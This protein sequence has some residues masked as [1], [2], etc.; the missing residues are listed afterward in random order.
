MS[1]QTKNQLTVLLNTNITD[2]LNKQNTA[3]KVREV[4]QS[5]IDS[6][7]ILSGSNSFVGDQTITGSLIV[8]G[9][10]I[11]TP[12]L[13]NQTDNISTIKSYENIINHGDLLIPLNC[14]FIVEEDAQYLI[15]GELINN[16]T[17]IVSGSLIANQGITGPGSVVGSGTVLNN[18]T[19]VTFDKANQA[20]GFPQLNNTGYGYLGFI[21][22]SPNLLSNYSTVAT[23]LDS[24]QSVYSIDTT[25]WNANTDYLHYYLPEGQYEGQ[26]VELIITGN[27]VN[28]GGGNAA[29]IQIWID[30]IR[31]PEYYGQLSGG[32]GGWQAFSDPNVF[33]NWRKDIPRAIW[34]NNAWTI[35]ND[36]Y[37][38]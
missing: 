36:L 14:T 35:D 4:I 2:A 8:N 15:L 34:M 32:P 23:S 3:S 16:G 22:G 29:R 10:I 17:V 7:G 12:F 1:Q 38:D 24:Q 5:N 26:S 21:S 30:S 18:N 28:L 19:I 31:R 6:L 11:Y 20:Y 33:G 27:G 25:G 37:W 9:N 13:Q